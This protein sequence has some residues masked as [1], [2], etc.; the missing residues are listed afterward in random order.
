MES[1]DHVRERCEAL[2]QWTAHWQPQT[3]PGERRRWWWPMTWPVVAVVV[4]GLA[5]ALPLSV[6]AKTFHCGAGD[7]PCLIAA[8]NTANANGETNT[9][10]LAAGTYTLTAVDNGSFSNA[11]GLPVITSP[12]TITG[13][14]ADN[15][16]I[17]R[18]ASAPRFRIL[19][20]AAAGTLT[21]KWLTLRGGESLGNGNGI[22]ND[23]TLT[24]VH[25]A[26]TSN[27]SA[28]CFSGGGIATSGTATIAH[29]TIADNLCLSS[30]GGLY[31]SGGTVTLH[32]ST[33]KDNLAQGGGGGIFNG[34][35][36]GVGGTVIITES[37]II[38]N[39]GDASG[40]GILNSGT[41]VITNTTI[42]AN[43]PL[44][45][46]GGGI[47][48]SGGTLLLT[49]S[50]VAGNISDGGGGG[51][52]QTGGTVL[53]LNT[54]LAQNSLTPFPLPGSGPDCAGSITSLDHNLIGDLTG[55]T[56]TLQPGD[57][58]GNPGL[59]AFTD[60]GRPGN[61]H[62][63]L[64]STSQAIDAGNDAL[65]PRTDQ[66]GRRRLGPCDIGAITFRDRDDRHHEDDDHHEKDDKHDKEHDDTD[67]V[68]A[69][70]VAQ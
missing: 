11:N 51:I 20:V 38:A 17:E 34:A 36:L 33:V 26:V 47:V 27:G 39:G 55:C 53:L 59:G 60:N 68:A 62:F 45:F 35:F 12:L 16:S 56:I 3:R 25:S 13:R 14:R 61:G 9:I 29:S 44:E 49:N 52:T 22:L 57:L 2:V 41:M 30:G 10:R 50:T 19:R 7:V 48:N 65:C 6:Q 31:I 23:G 40:G 66:L 63:P 46:M 37:A 32:A 28:S 24:L 4:L 58:T 42:A 1:M 54:I 69:V 5:L 8:I 43:H 15:T 18:D 67:P 70:H 64:L 21:L